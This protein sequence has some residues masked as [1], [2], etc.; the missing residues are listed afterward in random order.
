M[1]KLRTTCSSQALPDSELSS[2]CCC[3]LFICFH[4][5]SYASWVASSASLLFARI[6]MAF[7][8]TSWWCCSTNVRNRSF[9]RS[10]SSI[11]RVFV[12]RYLLIR[13]ATE[14]VTKLLNIYFQAA[15]RAGR[16]DNGKNRKN[17]GTGWILILL[18][19]QRHSFR[20]GRAG[21]W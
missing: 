6:Y 4:N 3:G 21:N 10:G 18:T 7:E 14:K 16:N 20:A 8:N 12:G 11:C 15:K 13:L 19:I 1:H 9:I 2:L 17:W 5:R